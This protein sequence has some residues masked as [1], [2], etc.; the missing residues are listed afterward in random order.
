MVSSVVIESGRDE[1]RGF[2][3]VERN[4]RPLF[5]NFGRGQV[6]LEYSVLGSMRWKDLSQRRVGVQKFFFEL[7]ATFSFGGV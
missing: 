2:W 1:R 4:R 7:P 6:I 5:S 3:R